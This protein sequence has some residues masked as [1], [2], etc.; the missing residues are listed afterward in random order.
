METIRQTIPRRSQDRESNQ[1]STATLPQSR[2]GGPSPLEEA[3]AWLEVG[4]EFAA[5]LTQEKAE[6]SLTLRRQQS[7]Q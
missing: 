1:D 6:R 2:V 4:R 5:D 3:E 7:G